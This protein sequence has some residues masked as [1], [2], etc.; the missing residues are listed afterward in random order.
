MPKTFHFL[1]LFVELNYITNYI[2][3]PLKTLPAENYVQFP[4]QNSLQKIIFSE[5][6][7]SLFS[8]LYIGSEPQ[9]IPV[10]IE[11]RTNDFLITS[12]HKLEKNASDYY[13]NKTIYNL[14]S[15]FLSGYDFFNENKSSSLS[16]EYC[17]ERKKSNKD[18]PISQVSCPAKDTFYF[19]EKKEKYFLYFEIGKNLKDNITGIIG[20]GL[21]DAYFRRT[22]SFLYVLNQNNITSNN[23]WFFDFDINDKNNSILIIGTLLDEIYKDKYDRKDLAFAN[24]NQG[25]SYWKI[26]FD[27]I[28]VKI[29]SYEYDLDEAYCELAY[30][31]N[32]II[33]NSKYK[34]YF[35][36]NLNDLIKQEKCFNEK[37]EGNNNFYSDKNN[38]I[39]YYCKNEKDVKEKLYDIILPIN[40]YSNELNYTFEINV[41]DIIKETNDFIFF[42]ILF[43]EK[44]L[45]YWILGKIFTLKYNF[46]FNP[47]LKKVGFYQK[48]K[49]LNPD[50]N[51]DNSTN[52]GDKNS[53][54]KTLLQILIII[55]CSILLIV[56]GI[57]IGKKIYG[58]KK[59]R[60]A[61]EMNDDDYEYLTDDK[62]EN[63]N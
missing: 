10:L 9:K 7:T 13:S 21:S 60:K 55:P 14:T 61:Y 22:S 4:F 48:F 25:Y 51:T 36:L 30:D 32:I 40:F 46:I 33:A 62:K 45:N 37:F 20:L 56:L 41:T 15:S 38:L 31:T 58:I 34:K 49:E 53:N 26:K 12:I 54:T 63:K 11:P 43:G 23:F 3:L 19:N 17:E 2:T 29:L 18:I 5:Y 8:E 24:A 59:K 44:N 28:Y 1:F 6:Y 42:K 57:L 16:C 35:E 47:E 27:K 52:N 50:N 39:F